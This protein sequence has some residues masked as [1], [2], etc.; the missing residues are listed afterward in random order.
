MTQRSYPTSSR[1]I[2]RRAWWGQPS[3]ARRSC[4]KTIVAVARLS[5]RPLEFYHVPARLGVCSYASVYPTDRTLSNGPAYWCSPRIRSRDSQE[6]GALYPEISGAQTMKGP[7]RNYTHPSNYTKTKTKNKTLPMLSVRQRGHD[8]GG[9]VAEKRKSGS[10][11]LHGNN[12]SAGNLM[13]AYRKAP[14]CF[15]NGESR[16]L[17]IKA[18]YL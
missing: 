7:R 4:T 1:V 18:F 9:C 17:E 16:G 15:V 5:H 2:T 14:V 13:P 3:Q 11:H 12:P 10:N 6:V 8:R